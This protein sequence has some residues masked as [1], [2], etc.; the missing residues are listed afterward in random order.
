MDVKRVLLPTVLALV[1]V[2]ASAFPVKAQGTDSID[3]DLEIWVNE[4]G[5]ARL[6]SGPLL[7][8][9]TESLGTIGVSLPSFEP[10]YKLARESNIDVLAVN[11]QGQVLD[12][13][14]NGL[15]IASIQVEEIVLE[16]LLQQYLPGFGDLLM[17]WLAQG[18]VAIVVYFGDQQ[19]DLIFEEMAGFPKPINFLEADVIISSAG[20]VV[21][22]AG[23]QP[24]QLGAEM[25]LGAEFMEIVEEFGIKAADLQVSG[26]VVNLAVN[27]DQWLQAT[28]NLPQVM[29]LGASHVP[30][31]YEEHVDLVSS[32][33]LDSD[34]TLHLQIADEPSTAPPHIAIGRP[35]IANLSEDG[36]LSVEGLELPM[37][38]P[39]I[40]TE[41]LGEGVVLTLDGPNGQIRS[42]EELEFTVNFE[43]GFVSRA[44]QAYLPESNLDWKWVDQLVKSTTVNLEITPVGSTVSLQPAEVDLKAAPVDLDVALIVP[45]I[46]GSDGSIGL[47][48]EKLPL[49]PFGLDANVKPL[50]P[51]VRPLRAFGISARG[52]VVDV[53]GAKMELVLVGETRRKILASTIDRYGIPFSESIVDALEYFFWLT[54]DRMVMVNIDHLDAPV[55]PGLLEQ[56]IELLKRY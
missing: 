43:S 48:G 28:L 49:E 54:R 14:A 33:V 32:W 36:M 20:E 45:M 7:C 13:G 44:G 34:T 31:G 3:P 22:L 38:V 55:P 27:G 39:E 50:I 47:W 30:A 16:E 25:Y 19:G 37:Q 12:V 40:V 8:F 23:L 42:S 29:E 53:N 24:S 2:A 17:P 6:C 56:G 26:N 10:L 9:D 41:L 1:L 52:A 15:Q 5:D 4:A 11:K 46:V 51:L 21:S 18:D 35:I